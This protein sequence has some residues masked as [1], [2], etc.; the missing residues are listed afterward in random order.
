MHET[1]TQQLLRNSRVVISQESKTVD[2]HS[3]L[4][5]QDTIKR[6]VILS[7]ALYSAGKMGDITL[8][9][10]AHSVDNMICP[11]VEQLVY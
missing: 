10:R 4:V 7:C 1:R 3:W 9:L 5:H 6:E 11:L 2:S 8:S